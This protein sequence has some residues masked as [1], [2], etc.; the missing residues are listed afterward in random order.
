MLRAISGD[1]SGTY[2]STGFIRKRRMVN[3]KKL[4]NSKLANPKINQIGGTRLQDIERRFA[5]PRLPPPDRYD[6]HDWYD[7]IGIT[8]DDIVA[9]CTESKKA[10]FGE[11]P[12]SEKEN[13]VGT[14]GKE[15]LS[16]NY[17]PRNDLPFEAYVNLVRKPAEKN[18]FD[19]CQLKYEPQPEMMD[20]ELRMCHSLVCSAP[21]RANSPRIGSEAEFQEKVRDPRYKTHHRKLQRCRVRNAHICEER[22]F[23]HLNTKDFVHIRNP[24]I[25]DCLFIA[26]H[27]YA[28]LQ[29][30]LRRGQKDLVTL[31][32]Q[33]GTTKHGYDMRTAAQ[34]LR[35][36]VIRWYRHNANRP[37][38]PKSY[39][40]QTVKQRLAL[41]MVDIGGERFIDIK[42]SISKINSL[43]LLGL[44][45]HGLELKSGELESIREDIANYQ[46]LSGVYKDSVQV[47]IDTLFGGYLDA[48][49]SIHTYGGSPEIEALS[50]LYHVNIFVVQETDHGYDTNQGAIVGAD[51]E[52]YYLHHS[53]RNIRG[54]STGGLH[55]EIFF[56]HEGRRLDYDTSPI[57]ADKVIDLGEGI[58]D[59][60]I[61]SSEVSSAETSPVNP[62]QDKSVMEELSE[63]EIQVL[64][65]T[66]ETKDLIYNILKDKPYMHEHLDTLS[67]LMFLNDQEFLD[68]ILVLSESLAE[69]DQLD[70]MEVLSE[71]GLATVSP[72]SA[73]PETE[74]PSTLIKNEALLELL[75]S[76]FENDIENMV[77]LGMDSEAFETYNILIENADKPAD[78]NEI[79]MNMLTAP[80]LEISSDEL[81]ALGFYDTEPS[82]TDMTLL[83]TLPY[84]SQN[85]LI[86]LGKHVST[87]TGAKGVRE[88]LDTLKSIKH[89]VQMNA[90]TTMMGIYA[91][92]IYAN[93]ELRQRLSVGEPPHRSMNLVHLIQYYIYPAF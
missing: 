13:I 91:T 26:F 9:K 25:G 20:D 52:N 37:Y 74:I 42:S 17:P 41:E 45:G 31:V 43:Q 11:R 34:E 12:A 49:I 65:A 48:M 38:D 72:T 51:A 4:T 21:E 28:Y 63:S 84:H 53:S 5:D 82:S 1:P 44:D 77:E 62:S 67:A 60:N 88:N 93:E 16:T 90:I 47:I 58:A 83:D 66:L 54:R 6:T 80:D 39:G 8:G 59:I 40:P 75:S 89:I 64:D 36:D 14:W 81:E 76:F 70:L 69:A 73:I 78:R 22:L 92:Q 15:A 68:N 35:Q 55:Y 29:A 2:L 24:G 10:G 86:M 32:N 33:R 79:W 30:Q 3:P 23:P 57:S 50:Q 18:I 27:H 87:K 19:Q 61:G 56:K 46:Q 7:V 85:I 71:R